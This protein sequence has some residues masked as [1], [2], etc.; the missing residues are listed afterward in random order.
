MT[1]CD[2]SLRG[3]ESDGH[4]L[5][6]NAE[7]SAL[8]RGN[9]AFP[10]RPISRRRSDEAIQSANA[11]C[12]YRLPRALRSLSWI[13]FSL[14]SAARLALPVLASSFVPRARLRLRL[15]TA[16]VRKSISQTDFE[17]FH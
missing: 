3:A 16:P 11:A 8:A 1:I 7:P 2:T 9:N 4:A 17:S 15:H 6:G 13:S 12:F 5:R 10:E 14:S